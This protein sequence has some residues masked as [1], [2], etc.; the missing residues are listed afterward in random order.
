M[1]R[2]QRQKKSIEEQIK[3]MDG[4]FVDEVLSMDADA[5]AKRLVGLVKNQQEIQKAKTDDDDLKRA[6]EVKK[7]LEETYS[8]PL[9]AIKL[10]LSFLV[11]L[12]KEKGK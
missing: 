7:G 10:K 4:S 8:L 1:A 9:K 3:E 6:A 2:K 5:L 11:Q 12:L